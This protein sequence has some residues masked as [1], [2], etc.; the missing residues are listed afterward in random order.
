MDQGSNVQKI[1]YPISRRAFIGGGLA[2]A[3]VMLDGRFA[4]TQAAEFAGAKITMGVGP[5]GTA[6]AMFIALKAGFLKEEGIEVSSQPQR[7]S[8]LAIKLMTGGKLQLASPAPAAFLNNAILR[9]SDPILVASAG[10]VS[11]KHRNIAVVVSDKLY[12]QGVKTVADLKGQLIHV[13]FGIDSSVGKSLLK[14]LKKFGVARNDV[15]FKNWFRIHQ[16]QQA[17]LTGVIDAAMLL[18]PNVTLF[19]RKAGIHPIYYADELSEG[20]HSIVFAMPRSWVEK[21]QEA[22][23]RI[24]KA[25]LRAVKIYKEAQASG[26]KRHPVVKQ[27]LMSV[28]RIPGEVID[29]YRGVAYEDVPLVHVDVLRRQMQIFV[30]K[31]TTKLVPPE[32]YVEMKYLRMAAKRLGM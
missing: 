1:Q 29:S 8:A 24:L 20:D 30:G 32:Q 11:A 3:M 15:K 7:N 27:T 22:T 21:N 16:M 2:S 25:Y 12:R 19:Q 14:S 26:W 17:I 31:G 6:A 4:T 18:E 23:I 9:G 28:I 5:S 13:Q 10:R